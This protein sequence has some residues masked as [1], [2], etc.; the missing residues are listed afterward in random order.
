M[1]TTI[2]K[3]AKGPDVALAQYVLCRGLYLG[4]PS[5]VDGDFGPH[6][7]QA[8]RAYQGDHNL[9]VD[10]IVGPHTWGAMLGEYPQPPTLSMHSQW[11]HVNR[12]QL[13]LNE[14]TPPAN[15]PLV[16]DGVFGPK[17]QQAVKVYQTA[18]GVPADGVVGYKTWVIHVGA[19]NVMVASIVGV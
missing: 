18:H 7:D 9:A 16:E 15:P 2:K 17:T 8:V 14:A 1:P 6:T 5:D 10:G 13:F 3:G 12:L 19:T 11:P 4:G